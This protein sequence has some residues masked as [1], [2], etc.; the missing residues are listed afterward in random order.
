[1]RGGNSKGEGV[2]RTQVRGVRKQYLG[3]MV[4]LTFFKHPTISRRDYERAA[5]FVFSDCERGM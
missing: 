4:E 1:M 5:K 2:A 3:E